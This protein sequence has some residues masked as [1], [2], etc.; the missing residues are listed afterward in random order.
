MANVI[1]PLSELAVETFVSER[2]KEE[3]F[4]FFDDR[5]DS[6]D[7]LNLRQFFSRPAA[8]RL[9][10][11]SHGLFGKSGSQREVGGHLQFTSH[12]YFLLINSLSKNHS[13]SA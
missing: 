6:L 4:T 10:L 11:R 5:V 1:H 2:D 8:Q 7:L 13:T 9:E 3:R 12:R